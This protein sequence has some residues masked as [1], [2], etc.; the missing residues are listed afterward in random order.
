MRDCGWLLP[1]PPRALGLKRY[2]S[3]ACLLVED[4][5][6]VVR[7]Q[8]EPFPHDLPEASKASAIP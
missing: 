7:V 1:F 8:V 5:E 2:K 3:I 4:D 6:R